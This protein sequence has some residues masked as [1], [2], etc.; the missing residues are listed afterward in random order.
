VRISEQDR[1][2]P[3]T[4]P[5]QPNYIALTAGDLHGVKDDANVDLDVR[6]LGDLLEARGLRWKV[7]ADGYPGSCQAD[8]RIGPYARKHVP[9]ISFRNVREDPARCA[10]IVN[11]SRM[12][13]DIAAGTLPDYS[14]FI[15]DM[16]HDGSR[17][18]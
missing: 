8:A 14:L 9:F 15:P 2:H 16:N 12:C 5:S 18:R 17:P 6:H 1:P 7:Y 10:N 11:A 13:E 4:H 3:L